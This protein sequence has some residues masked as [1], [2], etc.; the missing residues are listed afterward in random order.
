MILFGLHDWLAHY[1]T[2]LLQD[3]KIFK[4]KDKEQ[5]GMSKL[6]MT[7]FLKEKKDVF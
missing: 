6:L 7:P 4:N 2:H 3:F 1:M 5:T